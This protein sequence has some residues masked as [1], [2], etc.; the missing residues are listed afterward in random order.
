MEQ[1][2]N[3]E[4]FLVYT[5]HIFS[6]TDPIKTLCGVKM[7]E[8]VA[9]T[10]LHLTSTLKMFERPEA[11]DDWFLLY[12]FYFSFQRHSEWN[13]CPARLLDWKA[14]VPCRRWLIPTAPRGCGS[15][16]GGIL[17]PL[18]PDLTCK[19]SSA[20][21]CRQVSSFP[22]WHGHYGALWMACQSPM[23]ASQLVMSWGSW[24][25]FAGRVLT[26]ICRWGHTGS[27]LQFLITFYTL[28]V[29][30]VTVECSNQLCIF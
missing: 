16:N 28:T 18:T 30:H 23:V 19:R 9:I 4:I 22:S 27:G 7:I 20:A 10:L 8:E 13:H 21:S 1:T 2:S 12:C 11:A 24:G 6:R 15:N 25:M 26:F 14:P 17:F 5:K 29:G 3:S